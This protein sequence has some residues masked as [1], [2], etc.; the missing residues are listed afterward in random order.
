LRLLLYEDEMTTTFAQENLCEPQGSRL[1]HEELTGGIIAAAI[2]VHRELGPGLLESAYQSCLSHELSLR[3]IKFQTEAG[4]PVSY[5][6]IRLDCG[7]RMDLVVEGKVVIEVKSV[8][9]LLPIHQAQLLTY[10][11]LTGLRVG[12]LINFNVKVLRD[13][14]VRR[15]L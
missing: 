12:L 15:I 2:E 11:R 14:L 8:D 13:G 10:L 3:G 7:Y 4:L 5:K 6:D 9:R 1:L